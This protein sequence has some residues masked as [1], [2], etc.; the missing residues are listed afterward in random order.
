MN[1]YVKTLNNGSIYKNDLLL[2]ESYNIQ[3]FDPKT[4]VEHPGCMSITAM[5]G[6][7]KTVLIKYLLSVVHKHFDR[8]Y[9]ISSTAKLQPI[10]DFIPRE[11]I[12][13]TYN[14][15]FLD[16]LISDQAVMKMVI[17]DGVSVHPGASSSRHRKLVM[18][19]S[20]RCVGEHRAEVP[21]KLDNI[22]V[23]MDDIIHD[24]EYQKSQVLKRIFTSG[25]HI[26]VRVWFL[27]QNFTSLK[28]LQRNNVMWAI[29]FDL[30]AKREREKFAQSYLSAKNQRVGELIFD[31]IVKE[32]PYQCVVVEVY[33]NG[34]SVE[35]KVKK[36]TA[37]MDVEDFTIAKIKR[38]FF[39]LVK[40]DRSANEGL[41]I[42]RKGTQRLGEETSSRSDAS[43]RTGSSVDKEPRGGLVLF[44]G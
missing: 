44:R 41:V 10:Y 43:T 29:S 19:D 3:E 33:K 30:D 16:K 39:D 6:A 36:F 23:I 11:N 37:K 31:K 38:P 12:M 13:E 42:K 35:E 26:S 27:T 15:E 25:R 21:K 34:K 7:G 24:K 32:K 40:P 20:A 8:I 4:L 9:L 2:A 22:L 1:D 5:T 18:G 14:E 17:K 28:L